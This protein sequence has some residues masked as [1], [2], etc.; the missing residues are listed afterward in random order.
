MVQVSN[1]GPGRKSVDSQQVDRSADHLLQDVLRMN[2]NEVDQET[3][4]I[5]PPV[6][7]FGRLCHQRPIDLNSWKGVTAN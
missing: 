3:D 4:Q 1:L 7:G 5:E 2:Q 6:A